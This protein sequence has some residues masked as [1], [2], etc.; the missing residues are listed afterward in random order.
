MAPGGFTKR[1]QVLCVVLCHP[2]ILFHSGS[3]EISGLSN[4]NSHLYLTRWPLFVYNGEVPQTIHKC[5]W[6]IE[7]DCV[8]TTDFYDLLLSLPKMTHRNTARTNQ[9]CRCTMYVHPDMVLHELLLVAIKV[10]HVAHVVITRHAGLCCN[11]SC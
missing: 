8:L 5:T 11:A 3:L 7:L 9:T 6:F 2:A 1:G 4:T 10:L